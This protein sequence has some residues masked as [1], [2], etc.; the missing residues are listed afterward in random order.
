MKDIWNKDEFIFHAGGR[1]FSIPDY[2][3]VFLAF[4]EVK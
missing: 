3:V 1:S 4:E 2:G